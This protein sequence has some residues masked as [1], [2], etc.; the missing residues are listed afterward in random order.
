[1]AALRLASVAFAN[2]Q[3]GQ[4]ATDRF[5]C[6]RLIRQI[7]LGVDRDPG[8]QRVRSFGRPLPPGSGSTRAVERIGG[9]ECTRARLVSAS[10]P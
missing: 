1:V 10:W 7:V 3:S 8:V 9:L 6:G 5:R 4:A 2:E